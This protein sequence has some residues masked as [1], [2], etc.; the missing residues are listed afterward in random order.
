[1]VVIQ[2]ASEK[3]ENTKN[4]NA[5]IQGGD[6]EAP[7]P[8]NDDGNFYKC[9]T[10]NKVDSDNGDDENKGEEDINKDN[11]H[12]EN[13]EEVDGSKR[14]DLPKMLEDKNGQDKKKQKEN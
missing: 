9:F 4:S 6:V 12:K 8:Y 14:T 2:S 3:E 1:M 5:L 13:K 7:R 11:N 10:T